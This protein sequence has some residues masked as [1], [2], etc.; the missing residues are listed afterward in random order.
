ML[1]AALVSSHRDHPRAIV[2][3]SAVSEGAIDGLV[4]VHALGELWSVLTKLPVSPPISSRAA[5]EAIGDILAQ[6]E[7]VSLTLEIYMAAVARCASR[8]LRSGAIYDALHMATAEAAGVEVLLTFNERDFSRLSESAGP[9]IVV[10][11]DPPAV[12][13]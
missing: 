12:A 9:R 8:G 10:P 3:L 11:A 5:R 1:I 6:F 2:W 7:V 4:S 13:F